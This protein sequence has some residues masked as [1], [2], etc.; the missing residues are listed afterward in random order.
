MPKALRRAVQ[1]AVYGGCNNS[2]DILSLTDYQCNVI[3]NCH[4]NEHGLVF[5]RKGS[6]ILNTTSLGSAV[7]SIYDFRKPDGSSTASYL[8]VTAG[9]ALYKWNSTTSTF[10]LVTALSSSDRPSWVTFT[11][12]SNLSYAIMCNGTDFIKYDGTSV[13]NCDPAE[14]YPWTSNPRYIIEYDDRLLVS[15]CDS[16]PY[17]VFVSGLQDCTE[18]KPGT[19][20]AAVYWTIKGSKGERV[21]GL[22]VVYDYAVLFQRNATNIITEADPESTSSQQITVSTRYGTTSHWSIQGINNMLYFCDEAHVYKGALRQAIENGLDV[23]VIDRNIQE[24]Y[25]TVTNHSDIVSVYDPEHEEIQWGVKTG[26][27]VKNDTALVYNIG[28]SQDDNPAQQTNVWSGWFD[29]DGYEPYTLA[30]VIQSDGS[31]KVYRGDETGY[32]YVMEEDFKYKDDTTDG[33]TTTQNPIPVEI[34]T[35]GMIPYG[36]GTRKRA[37]MFVPYISQRH[38]GSV[39]VQWVVDRC[40]ANATPRQMQLYNRIPYWR[41]TTNTTNK[42]LWNKTIWAD[43]AIMPKS[44][45]LQQ[46]F[47]YI[48]FVMTCA[49]TNATD[50]IT[51]S[52]CEFLYQLHSTSIVK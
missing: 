1:P 36:L 41:A 7:T 51:Y 44:I 27:N 24:K 29:G 14:D 17:K 31:T 50:E 42:Q 28:L 9:E 21:T 22:G 3:R 10:T 52:G 15:G 8:L 37:R 11:D 45:V 25:A 2:T 43:N 34:R 47:S 33:A 18:W 20:G 23:V 38:N 49:G 30:S 32:V 6:N 5:T 16:D 40:Y 35:K 48:Q 46:P 26:F 19:G 13:T 4:I 39:Y 12:G